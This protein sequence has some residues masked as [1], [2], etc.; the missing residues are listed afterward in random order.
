MSHAWTVGGKGACERRS[1]A[2]P[3]L[4]LEPCGVEF[5]ARRERPTARFVL[6]FRSAVALWLGDG[7]AWRPFVT[8][9]ALFFRGP[10]SV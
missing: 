10:M 1:A 2:T 8:S 3:G 6:T 4:A 9:N 7:R 5:C